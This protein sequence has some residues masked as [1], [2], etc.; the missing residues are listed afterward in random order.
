MSLTNSSPN[1]NYLDLLEEYLNDDS[2][3]L[4]T[5]TYP[6]VNDNNNNTNNVSEKLDTTDDILS[7]LEDSP[8]KGCA[9]L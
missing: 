6:T 9:N 2:T 4:Q 5:Q 3:S 8:P 7:W 1:S